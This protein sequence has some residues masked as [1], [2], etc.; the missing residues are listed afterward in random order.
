MIRPSLRQ[1]SQAACWERGFSLLELLVV[2][3]IIV[4]L[5]ALLTPAL[6]CAKCRANRISC[7]GNLRQLGVGMALYSDTYDDILPPPVFNPEANPMAGPYKSYFLFY[8]PAGLA[9]DIT[10]PVNLGYFYST[11]LIPAPATFY[12]PGLPHPNVLPIPFELRNYTSVKSGWP[13]ADDIAANVR[14]N[15]MYY[16]QSEIPAFKDP[17]PG[18]E[19]WS[20]V[21]SNRHQLSPN[22]TVATDLIYTR[23]TR[24]H[25]AQS[26][27]TGL[28]GLWGDGHVSFSVTKCAFAPDLWDPYDDQLTLQNPG[29]NPTKF[30]MIVSLLRP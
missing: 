24:P 17:A 30:R 2:I 6:A 29:D 3:F 7:A 10:K 23:R 4:M 28:N 18:Q 8:G 11:G 9:V 16:P 21:A 1:T 25:A 13:K 27:P 26:N 12:D 14:G 15:Y 5:A 20:L 22:R 19:T